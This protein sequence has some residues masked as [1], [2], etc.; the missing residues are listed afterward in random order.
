MPDGESKIPKS[1][2][3]LVTCDYLECIER[4]E[5]TNCYLDL[6]KRCRIYINYEIE[7]LRKHEID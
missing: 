2:L 7:K 3:N 5:Y 6:E 1:D 4:G